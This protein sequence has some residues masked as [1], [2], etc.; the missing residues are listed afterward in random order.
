[1]QKKCKK[2]VVILREYGIIKNMAQYKIKDGEELRIA[3]SGKSGCGNTT[4]S[5]MI[6]ERLGIKLLG[7]LQKSVE[8]HLKKLSKKQKLI[9]VTI[10]MSTRTKLNL[11]K[12]SLVC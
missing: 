12:K 5:T 9:L 7:T 6:A 4:I 8:F 10:N 1:M 2:N 3:I 11:Q